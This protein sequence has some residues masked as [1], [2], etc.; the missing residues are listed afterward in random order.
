MRTLEIALQS[1]LANLQA[2]TVWELPF[3]RRS[4]H[5]GVPNS[6]CPPGQQKTARG[7]AAPKTAR[8]RRGGSSAGGLSALCCA[9]CGYGFLVTMWRCEG[10]GRVPAA[11]APKAWFPVLTPIAYVG[12]FLLV[13]CAF[14]VAVSGVVE[15]PEVMRQRYDPKYI[16]ETNQVM[17][18]LGT[19]ASP[20]SR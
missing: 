4:K 11:A 9:V 20:H 18:A 14:L 3:A 8:G 16:H 19:A 17:C 1:K 5:T 6:P 2:A 12:V 7:G 15:T 10:A 13:G